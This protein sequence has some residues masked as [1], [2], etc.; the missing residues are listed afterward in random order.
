[1][2]LKPLFGI[3]VPTFS[4]V[5]APALEDTA[6]RPHHPPRLP[7]STLRRSLCP[8][9]PVPLLP[10]VALPHLCRSPEVDVMVIY[11]CLSLVVN[12]RPLIFFF[13]RKNLM[14]VLPSHFWWYKAFTVKWFDSHDHLYGQT[15]VI[16]WR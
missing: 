16:F 13:Y 14:L 4:M 11:A 1:M 15:K 12:K 6:L 3:P 9:L 10:S 5:K 2:I 7:S 8:R